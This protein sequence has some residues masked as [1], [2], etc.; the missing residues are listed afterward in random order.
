MKSP[1]D[2]N[3]FFPRRNFLK[4]LGVLGSSNLLGLPA[5]AQQSIE[6]AQYGTNEMSTAY[7]QLPA[8][9]QL[10]PLDLR[11]VKVSGIIGRR[12]DMTIYNNLMKLD[13]E[14]F[15]EPFRKKQ[16][17]G[18]GYSDYIGLGKNIDAAVRLAAYKKDE[19]LIALKKR[20]VQETIKTQEP[21]GYIG[22]M[23]KTSRMW[24]LWDIHE[25][26]YIIMGLANDYEYFGEKRSLEAARK[27]ADYIIERWSTKPN[28]WLSWKQLGIES[29]ILSLYY[30]TKEKRYLDFCTEQ[31]KLPAWKIDL[32][33]TTIGKTHM[34]T[35]IDLCLAQLDLYQS[36]P[37]DTLLESSRKAIDF[38][39]QHNGM[40]I[41]G[42]AGL[43][44]SWNGDQGGRSYLGETCASAYQLRLLDRFMRMQAD[45]KYGDVMERIIY[46]ALFA[47]QSPDGRQLRYFT[48][49]E[50]NRVY[51]KP[52]TYCCPNNFRR[53]IA[54]LPAL[55][56]YK[57]DKGVA[58]NLYTS[59]E[60]TVELN[61]KVAVQLQQQ[62]DYP[63]SGIVNVQVNPTVA[64]T[65]SLLLRIPSWCT[66]ATVN[67]NGKPWTQPAVPGE[68]L[69]IER[70][71]QKGD[72][73]VLDMPM[74]F[75]LIAGRV[76][77]AGRAAIM[78]GPQLYCF[79]PAQQPATKDKDAADL[80]N[81]IIDPASLKSITDDSVEPGG[82]ACT[83]LMGDRLLTIGEPMKI[84]FTAF[85]DPEGKVVYFRVPDFSVAQP[86]ELLKGNA[87]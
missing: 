16:L 53:I 46:N 40:V 74:P 67:V 76:H 6:N 64:S 30:V 86:D 18:E 66:Q 4:T 27:L 5:I 51:F 52:D 72:T 58:V 87:Y 32:D 20:L 77:Q 35:D 57:T 79:N 1:G 15:L 37:D 25:M 61:K 84:K 17:K 29:N 78:R 45:A 11:Q 42:A 85:P 54:V 34:Y 26:G 50:G 19:Q 70:Q 41:T 69:T 59:A 2:N 62:T 3:R 12:I 63:H 44:E 22:V 60:T 39:L 82:I 43:W 81:F 31:L 14:V 24:K 23:I 56:F 48:P 7:K 55:V 38:L 8:S 10:S 28:D 36:Q 49:M 71:W 47:A 33:E 68:F 80:T 21:D 13:L 75:R 65:F 83:G 9:K 73:V